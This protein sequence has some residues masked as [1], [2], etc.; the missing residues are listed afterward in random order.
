MRN[1]ACNTNAQERLN[2]GFAARFG[3]ARCINRE[4]SPIFCVAIIRHNFIRPHG[5]M[6]GRTPAEA[7]GT[8]MR[9]HGKWLTLIRNAA[10]AS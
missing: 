1:M 3:S 4:D 5:G 9:A 2:G 10:A 7:T 6:G 8:G